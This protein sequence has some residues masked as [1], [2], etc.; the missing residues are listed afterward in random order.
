VK[1]PHDHRR[2]E[3]PGRSLRAEVPQD[4]QGACRDRVK[5]RERNCRRSFDRARVEECIERLE[6]E[7]RRADAP[8]KPKG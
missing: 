4:C 3:K 2:P 8:H 5:H 6:R 1:L 7:M